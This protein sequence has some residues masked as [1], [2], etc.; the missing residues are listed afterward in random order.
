MIYKCIFQCTANRQFIQ[1]SWLFKI[2]VKG[3]GMENHNPS[4]LKPIEL[5]DR[6]CKFC[7]FIM[8]DFENFP[9]T[10]IA[11]YIMIWYLI[12]LNNNFL[13]KNIKFKIVYFCFPFLTRLRKERGYLLFGFKGNK[14]KYDLET[15]A[16]IAKMRKSYIM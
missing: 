1:P 14:L 15:E 16:T 4:K 2:F 6:Y 13:V 10:Y 9:G 12:E 11:N 5:R 3:N 8:H 7:T